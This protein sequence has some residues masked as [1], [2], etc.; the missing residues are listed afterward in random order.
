MM[1]LAL[2]QVSHAVNVQ[3][4]QQSIFT[5]RLL[6]NVGLSGAVLPCWGSHVPAVHLPVLQRVL[7][8]VLPAAV[9]ELVI[10][11][12]ALRWVLGVAI[13]KLARRVLG[14]GDHA[15]YPSR[16]SASSLPSMFV[17]ALLCR[18]LLSLVLLV[19]FLASSTEALV[20]ELEVGHKDGVVLAGER[21]GADDS[22]ST[23][24]APANKVHLCSCTHI[25]VRPAVLPEVTSAIGAA[26]APA[27]HALVVTPLDR[28]QL[29]PV[30]P[31]IA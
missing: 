13:V 20:C 30:P 4:Q 17:R 18:S 12:G 2:A 7:H 25:V 24:P 14:L 19:A 10:G 16:R 27:P 28:T 1:T 29:P 8:N 15:D 6:T 5:A 3:S 31:P 21:S 26:A 22:D 11:A 9:D 23:R